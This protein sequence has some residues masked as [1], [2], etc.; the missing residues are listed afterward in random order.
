MEHV[1]SAIEAGK[2]DKI[3]KALAAFNDKVQ[4]LAVMC[5]AKPFIFALHFFPFCDFAIALTRYIALTSTFLV[6]KV[7]HDLHVHVY[8]AVLGCVG[9]FLSVYVLCLLEDNVSFDKSRARP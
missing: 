3:S 2:E 6:C 8:S 9:V 5:S 4:L 1:L 7:Y